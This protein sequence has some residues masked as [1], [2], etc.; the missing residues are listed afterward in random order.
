M[1]NWFSKNIG[2]SFVIQKIEY[3]N[4]K[5]NILIKVFLLTH[6]IVVVFMIHL[7]AIRDIIFKHILLNKS[8]S[9]YHK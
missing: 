1:Y 2:K 6:K 9:A 7:S 4:Q 8:A 5:E 3:D